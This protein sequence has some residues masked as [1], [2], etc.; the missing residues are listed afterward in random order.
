M[1]GLKRLLAFAAALIMTLSGVLPSFAAPAEKAG[2]RSVFLLSPSCSEGVTAAPTSEGS[3]EILA[4]VSGNRLVFEET[5]TLSVT[6]TF[7]EGWLA[8]ERYSHFFPNDSRTTVT[9]LPDGS[10]LCEF[11]ASANGG[12]S[13]DE[14]NGVRFNASVS[15][16]PK[17]YVDA[18]LPFDEI[19]KENWVSASFTLTEGTKDFPGGD[20]EGTGSVKGRGNSSWTNPKKPY[21]IKLDSKASLLGIPK[22]KKYA[23]VPSYN[24]NALMR[25]YITYK[26]YQG[27]VGIGYVPK[28]EF[29]DVYL[30]GVYNGVYILVERIAIEGSKVDIEEADADNMSGGYLIEKDVEQKVD[31]DSDLWFDC[32]YWANQSKDMFV[33]KSPEPDDEELTSAML[34]YLTDYMQRVH[35]SI[36]GISGEDWHTYVDVSSWV[37]FLIVQEISKNI[38][39]NFKTSC[40]LYKDRGDDHI[41]MTA[42]WDFDLAYGRVSWNNQSEEHNDVDDCPDANTAEGFMA[43]NS[44]NPWMDRLYDTVPEF[45]NALKRRYTAYRETL[46]PEMLRLL[47]ETAAYLDIAQQPNQELWGFN[48]HNGVTVLKNWLNRRIEW[49]DGEWLTDLNFAQGDVNLDG[50]VDSSDAM[51]ILRYSL[52]LG[53]IEDDAMPLADMNGDGLINAAD[54][55]VILRIAL[56]LGKHGG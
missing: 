16:L 48:F 3:M 49:L 9:E 33:L 22:T 35:D 42:P 5:K 4:R 26:T 17:L 20:Y 43:I 28:C 12:V 25:N 30:N 41:Y 50:N 53:L 40:W 1:K 7:D 14:W 8:C 13:L 2:E 24:D 34:A 18:E 52:G 31:P 37:D 32:P 56:G 47:E 46:I 11:T 45:R 19:G 29:V 6:V 54:A 23:I 10:L 38:D 55:L 44:S 51:L 27:L 39:G 15:E 21:S 36:M